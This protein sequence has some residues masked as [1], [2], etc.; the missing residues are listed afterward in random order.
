MF[1][2][3][4]KNMKDDQDEMGAVFVFKMCYELSWKILKRM[5]AAQGVES[6]APRDVFRKA[7]IAHLIDNPDAWFSFIEKRHL[8]SHAYEQENLDAIVQSFDSFSAELDNLV[9]RIKS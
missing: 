3:F 7:G 6:T 1:E 8:T 9:K 2:R 5:L 4:R